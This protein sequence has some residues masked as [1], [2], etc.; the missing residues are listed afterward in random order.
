MLEIVTAAVELDR[1]LVSCRARYWIYMYSHHDM[2]L[3]THEPRDYYKIPMY[4]FSCWGNKIESALPGMQLR[5][6]EKYKV[7][8]AVA[9]T[10]VK[11]G[12]HEGEGYER[13]QRIANRRVLIERGGV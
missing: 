13:L 10:L 6:G 12:D 8:F 3:S 5:T 7:A 9:P 11:F 4:G 1:R 2:Y